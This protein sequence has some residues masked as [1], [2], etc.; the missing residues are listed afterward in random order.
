MRLKLLKKMSKDMKNMVIERE[1]N[2]VSYLIYLDL[3]FL[4]IF[5]K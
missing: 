5:I 2:L 4:I 3:N 1:S